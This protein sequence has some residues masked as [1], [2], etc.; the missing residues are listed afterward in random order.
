MTPCDFRPIQVRLTSDPNKRLLSLPQEDDQESLATTNS[1]DA[2][3][4]QVRTLMTD[5]ARFEVRAEHLEILNECDILTP[6]AT[7]VRPYPPYIQE[8]T[9]LLGKIREVR[10]EAARRV[11]ELAHAD[12]DRQA[13]RLQAEGE[14]LISTIDGLM[15]GKTSSPVYARLEHTAALVGKT[16]A[17]L[18]AQLQDRRDF[19]AQR[20]PTAKDWDDFFRY[21]T[22]S[23]RSKGNQTPG[24]EIT[25]SDRRQAERDDAKEIRQN[26]QDDLD[27]E[28][29]APARSQNKKRKRE[30]A[31][32]STSGPYRIPKKSDRRQHDLNRDH[33]R[34][35]R[36]Q[37]HQNRERR[38]LRD[39][40]PPTTSRRDQDFGDS[41]P[42]TAYRTTYYRTD[43]DGKRGRD[44]YQYRD[45]ARTQAHS[46]PRNDRDQEERDRQLQ[47]LQQQQD[48]LRRK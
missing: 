33:R 26:L 12:F 25:P 18:T 7:T 45:P 39:P 28:E 10:K 34:R 16:K 30:Q 17:E 15:K 46:H 31:T 43:Q 27:S 44:H 20:Q 24:F 23:R 42:T 41:R 40:S 29:A 37:H 21:N 22:A 3:L 9:R 1:V 48:R 2:L 14:T 32:A 36:G 8:N 47:E 38:G 5:A 11:Q 4:D 13:S 35:D 19:L 6:W